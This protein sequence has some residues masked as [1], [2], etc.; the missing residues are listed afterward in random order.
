MS[1]ANIGYTCILTAAVG[2]GIP[3]L[4]NEPSFVLLCGQQ[5]LAT[6][7]Q[8]SPAAPTVHQPCDDIYGDDGI[9]LPPPSVLQAYIPPCNGIRYVTTYINTG[10]SLTCHTFQKYYS[11]RYASHDTSGAA[12]ASGSDRMTNE[13]GGNGGVGGNAG[14]SLELPAVE[15]PVKKQLRKLTHQTVK[16]QRAHNLA[17][18]GMWLTLF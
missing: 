9:A 14:V 12:T 10:K 11:S 5:Q 13:N 7:S 16:I 17:L 15:A 1:K 18:K 3:R 6:S 2:D 8:I 4:L